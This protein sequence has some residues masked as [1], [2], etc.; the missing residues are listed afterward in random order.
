MAKSKKLKFKSFVW[1]N[2]FAEENWQLRNL[3]V[4]VFGECG[5]DVLDVVLFF[6]GG[7]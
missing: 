4:G 5:I 7:V 2:D 1:K 3:I 6:V